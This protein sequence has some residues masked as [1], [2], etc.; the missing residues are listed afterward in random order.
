MKI[1]IDFMD[2]KL[3][4]L[5]F[6][7]KKKSQETE[8]PNEIEILKLLY[9]TFGKQNV[10]GCC[11]F[12]TFSIISIIVGVLVVYFTSPDPSNVCNFDFKRTMKSSVVSDSDPRVVALGDVN[13]DHLLDI[14]AANSGTDTIGV[15]L[16][17]S[18]SNFT[19]QQAYPTGHGSHP[20]SLV[21][22]D[23]NNDTYLDVAV[24]NYGTN[25][26]GIFLGNKTGGYAQQKNY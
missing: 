10:I 7:K 23:F 26:I 12:G 24:A 2:T 20:T 9:S 11:M 5:N 17:L 14:V 8:N 16:S 19:D 1:E 15:F 25:N 6:D 4:S 18:N 13:N 21:L 22:T 3:V